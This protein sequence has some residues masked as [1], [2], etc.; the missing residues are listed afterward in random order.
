MEGYSDSI[1][2][3]RGQMIFPSRDATTV[4]RQWTTSNPFC[5]SHPK[6][7]ETKKC[8]AVSKASGNQKKYRSMGMS[9]SRLEVIFSPWQQAIIWNLNC[10]KQCSCPT[11]LVLLLSPIAAP[12]PQV[13][14]LVCIHQL[15]ST[16]KNWENN[17]YKTEGFRG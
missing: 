13:H 12:G 7:E 8:F 10:T 14:P 6:Y 5:C 2:T 11:P 1:A 15:S 3:L 16:K 4:F 17:C 9:K